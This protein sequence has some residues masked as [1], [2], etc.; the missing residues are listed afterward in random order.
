V[1]QPGEFGEEVAMAI[2]DVAH[3]PELS[4]KTAMEVFQKHLAG[5]Y[6]I[7]K[8]KR[9]VTRDFVVERHPLVGVFVGLRQKKDGTSFVFHGGSPS[10]TVE[11][12]F[13]LMLGLVP[14]LFVYFIVLRPKHK[15]MEREA[16][17]FIEN[18][19]EFK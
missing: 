5:K 9:V 8:V 18:A 19:P 14:A 2:V 3:H 1:A 16:K 4:P 12:L 15:A 11:L 7:R 10:A 17:S 13:W 6:R